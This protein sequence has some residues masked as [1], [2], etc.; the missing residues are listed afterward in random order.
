MFISTL[1]L[2]LLELSSEFHISNFCWPKY[3]G[4][5]S[6][7]FARTDRLCLPLE[8]MELSRL[9]YYLQ[10]NSPAPL[11]LTQGFATSSLSHAF[12]SLTHFPF[13]STASSTS[14]TAIVFVADEISVWQMNVPSGYFCSFFREDA[15]YSLDF[16]IKTKNGEKRGGCPVRQPIFLAR[17]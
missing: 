3:F 2:N 6:F 12:F 8:A 17:T 14:S 9:I 5:W 13:L 1:V 7:G 10:V 11:P 4:M 15:N 16:G